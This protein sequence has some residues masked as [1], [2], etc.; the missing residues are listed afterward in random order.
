MSR[1][2]HIIIRHI[3][4]GVVKTI[5]RGLEWESE[6]RGGGG[7]MKSE[8]SRASIKKELVAQVERPLGRRD[9]VSLGFHFQTGHE[10]NPWTSFSS[11]TASGHPAVMGTWR[12]NKGKIVWLQMQKMR[13]ILPRKMRPCGSESQ[14]QGR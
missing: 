7:Q 9:E 10:Q 1:Q 6:K 13:C 2:N 14:F 11:Y 12:N 8:Y 3:F 5:E 4:A